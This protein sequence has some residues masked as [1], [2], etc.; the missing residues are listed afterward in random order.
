VQGEGFLIKH[1]IFGENCESWYTIFG[2]FFL[3]EF[4]GQLDIYFKKPSPY[5]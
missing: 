3:M 1:D 2:G 5:N 4:L